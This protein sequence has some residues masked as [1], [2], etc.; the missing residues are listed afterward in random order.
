MMMEIKGLLLRSC[1]EAC[2]HW[3]LAEVGLLRGPRTDSPDITP[4]PDT[5]I[6]FSSANSSF[7]AFVKSSL[8]ALPL[9]DGWVHGSE[10]DSN[11]SCRLNSQQPYSSWPYFL[12]CEMETVLMLTGRVLWPAEERSLEML[13]TAKCPACVS[14]REWKAGIEPRDHRIL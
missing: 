7:R 9:G 1:D 4:A 10:M 13:E 6:P 11:P 8:S 12:I 14:S 3:S 2:G 5:D